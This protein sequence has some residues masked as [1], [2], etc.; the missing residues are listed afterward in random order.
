MSSTISVV[1]TVPLS[2]RRSGVWF[3]IC[4]DEDMQ[5][6]IMYVTGKDGEGHCMRVGEYDDVT[7][8][9]IRPDMFGKDVVIEFE[10]E[11]KTSAE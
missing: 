10:Y 2:T 8:I 11:T 1:A 4:Y 3:F 5:K 7:D 6:I 9:V